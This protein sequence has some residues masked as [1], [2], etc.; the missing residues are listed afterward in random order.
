MTSRSASCARSPNSTLAAAATAMAVH[1][2]AS[3]SSA[4]NPSRQPCAKTNSTAIRTSKTRQFDVLHNNVMTAA[5]I[6]RHTAHRSW[7]PPRQPWVIHMTWRDLLFAH[8][9]VAVEHLRAVVPEPLPIDTYDGS[10]WVGVIPFVID[11]DVR[12]VPLLRRT[13]ELNV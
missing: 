7:P 4:F 3:C 12:G 9:P 13:P 6:L 1:T 8:W 2:Q 5:E 10:A 11:M